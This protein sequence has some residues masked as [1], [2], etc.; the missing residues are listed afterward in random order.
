MSSSNER[1]EL[2]DG[3]PIRIEVKVSDL[4]RWARDLNEVARTKV[5]YS[6]DQLRMANA[7]IDSMRHDIKTIAGF[8]EQARRGINRG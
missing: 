1:P 8:I 4:E 3:G 2:R 5:E 7:T 6:E